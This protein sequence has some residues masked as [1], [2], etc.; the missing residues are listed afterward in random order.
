MQYVL[1]SRR[2]Y[3]PGSGGGSPGCFRWVVATAA[4]VTVPP[5]PKLPVRNRTPAGTLPSFIPPTAPAARSRGRSA[6]PAPGPARFRRPRDAAVSRRPAPPDSAARRSPGHAPI[7]A[8]ALPAAPQPPVFGRQRQHGRRM[9][10]QPRPPGA[11][12]GSPGSRAGP[13]IIVK[14]YLVVIAPSETS[15]GH[16]SVTARRLVN[17]SLSDNTRRAYAG[18][19]GQLDAWLDGR[20][21]DDAALAAV[22]A[23]CH[24]PRPR[25]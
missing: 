19:L 5:P 21:L 24:L 10:R 14:D 11:T 25:V 12:P 13:T 15:I 7:P 20:K 16:S 4:T 23:T 6:A 2:P 22:L 9:P 18:A 1:T 17:A 3:A 8:G